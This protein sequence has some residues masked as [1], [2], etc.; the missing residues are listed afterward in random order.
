MF[1]RERDASK[2]AL[3]ALVE[4]LKRGGTVLLDV[5]FLTRHL[6]SFGAVEISREH[7]L[8]LLHQALNQSAMW[9]L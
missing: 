1:S 4:G 8:T 6:E 9:T 7:Y 3:V 5:Q 2:V